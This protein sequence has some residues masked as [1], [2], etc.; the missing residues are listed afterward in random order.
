M[1]GL[2]RF[3]QGCGYAVAGYTAALVGVLSTPIA[4]P[5]LAGCATKTAINQNYNKRIE[6]WPFLCYGCGIDNFRR[7]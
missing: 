7:I 5:R 1:N 6:K 2:S 4:L 3:G